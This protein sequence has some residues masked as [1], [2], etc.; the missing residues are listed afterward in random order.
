MSIVDDIGTGLDI[1]LRPSRRRNKNEKPSDNPLVRIYDDIEQNTP[2]PAPPG[3]LM[4]DGRRIPEPVRTGVNTGV[5]PYYGGTCED[6]SREVFYG[7]LTLNGVTNVSPIFSC[8]PKIPAAQPG[9][10]PFTGGQCYE[11]YN[12]ETTVNFAYTSPS[13]GTVP[14][15]G[16]FYGGATG[17][18]VGIRIDKQSNGFQVFL[19]Y[20]PTPTSSTQSVSLGGSSGPN[21]L[22][23]AYQGATSVTRVD[24]LPDDCGDPPLDP[25][26]PSPGQPQPDRRFPPGP[27]PG[28]PLPPE[29]IG[30]PEFPVPYDF[31]PP[32]T[33]PWP[34]LGDPQMRELPLPKDPPQWYYDPPSWYNTDPPGQIVG[35]I[36]QDKCPDPCPPAIDISP[37]LDFKFGDLKLNFEAQFTAIIG[38]LGVLAGGIAN[39]QAQVNL[40]AQINAKLDLVLNANLELKAEVNAQLIAIG[41][42]LAGIL[43]KLDFDFSPTIEFSPTIDFN[44]QIEISPEFNAEINFKLEQILR[45]VGQIEIN[46]QIK[47]SP[48][49]DFNPQIDFSPT[50]EISPQLALEIMLKLELLLRLIE[51]NKCEVKIIETEKIVEVTIEK[52]PPTENLTLPTVKCEDKKN[53][54]QELQTIKTLVGAVPVEVR[55]KFQDTATLA[56]EACEEDKETHCEVLLPSDIYQELNVESQLMIRFGTE[57]PKTTGWGTRIHIPNP[58]ANLDWC[59]HFDDLKWERGP[60][61]GRVYFENSGIYTGGYFKDEE[62]A[63]RVLNQ[64]KALSKSAV[65]RPFRI[66]KEGSPRRNP[67]Q[68]RT[69]AVRAVVAIMAPGGEILEKRCY[70]PPPPEKPC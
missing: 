44:P 67:V 35:P 55:Q 65:T 39:L 70:C 43:A 4:P 26:A 46:P 58:I 20:Q 10:R 18:L 40:I 9:S 34:D 13:Q 27:A 5:I 23:Y 41:G 60:I 12:V 63:K 37:E 3:A 50:I 66:T 47:F 49:I 56:L 45:L 11:A 2:E 17:R 64:L 8:P 57:Y 62:E 53:P 15:T 42:I 31:P 33:F 16:T 1:F 19:D 48:T 59:T 25:T 28:E 32:G 69:R 6:G 21:P 68:Q 24:G 51:E 61:V 14:E 22:A 52:E 30:D 7:E 38:L 29:T 36:P 54:V